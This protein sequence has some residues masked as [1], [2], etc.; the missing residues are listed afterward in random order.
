MLA[1]SAIKNEQNAIKI[2]IDFDYAKTKQKALLLVQDVETRWN[3]TFLILERLNK[4]KFSVLYY[5]A[6]YKNDQISNITPEEL[7][8]VYDII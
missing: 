2:Q 1:I 7:Q 6:N 8:L 5:M 4:L 3:S